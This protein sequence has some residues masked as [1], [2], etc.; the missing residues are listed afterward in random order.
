MDAEIDHLLVTVETS[1]CIFIRNGREHSASVAK[2]HLAL[3]RRRGKRFYDNA[4]EF[5]DR[6]ASKSSW[7]GKPYAIRC[8]DGVA[9]SAE[10]WFSRVLAEYRQSR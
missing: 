5:I 6:I 9:E 4:D 2:D 8:E 1:D 3:K 7:S 10:S